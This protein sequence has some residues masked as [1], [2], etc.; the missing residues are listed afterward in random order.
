MKLPKLGGYATFASICGFLILVAFSKLRLGRFVD[1]NDPTKAMNAMLSSPADFYAINLLLMV[2][3]ILGFTAFLALNEKMQAKAPHLMR[4]ATIATSITTAAIIFMAISGTQLIELI[5]P[6]KDV[7]SYRAFNAMYSTMWVASG[8]AM[9][10]ACLLIGCAALG[11]G[12]FPKTPAWCYIL[13]G[14]L[15]VRIPIPINRGLVFISYLLWL[16]GYVW[17]GIELLREKRAEP[18]VKEFSAG[19][20]E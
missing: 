8:H 5:A 12:M 3:I 15:W 9:G 18:I 13:A 11:T 17:F 10:W 19:Q 6:T 2:S 14:I 4:A 16:L 20:A 1:W 7:S